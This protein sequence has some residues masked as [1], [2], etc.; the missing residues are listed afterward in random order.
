MHVQVCVDMSGYV[1]V[2]VGVSVY[3]ECVRACR[4]VVQVCVCVYI[5]CFVS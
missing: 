3:I 5:W 4:C 1:L 2:C